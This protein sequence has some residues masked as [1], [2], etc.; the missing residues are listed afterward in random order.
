MYESRVTEADSKQGEINHAIFFASPLIVSPQLV[1]LLESKRSSL[2][3][4][5]VDTPGQI[6]CFTWSASGSILLESFASAFPTVLLYVSDLP[7]CAQPRTFVSSMLYAVSVLYRTRFKLICY[8]KTRERSG[9][10]SSHLS[11]CIFFF[12]RMIQVAPACGAEQM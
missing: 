6:E 3:V 7:R 11:H 10:D 5:V 4:I 9:P 12:K 8:H 2:D 1:D